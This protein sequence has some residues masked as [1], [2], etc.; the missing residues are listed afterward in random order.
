MAFVV[1]AP[2]SA[3]KRNSDVYKHPE[4]SRVYQRELIR[5]P[6]LEG[7]VTMKCDF[8]THTVFSDGKVWPTVRVDEAWGEGLDAVAITDHIEYRPN[9]KI[10]IAD[11]NESNEIAS[12]HAE[13]IGMIV[14]RGTEITRRK[15][16]G[17]LNALFIRDV[18]KL[19]VDDPEAAID[20]AVRQG[21]FIQ[22]NHPGWPND[23][24]TMYAVHREL[25]GKKKIHGVEVFGNNF[26]LYPK[27]IDW[28]RE[29]GLAAMGNSDIHSTSA[30]TYGTEKMARPMTLVFA[31]ERTAEGIKEA[32]FAGRTLVYFFGKLAGRED[33][34]EELVR[35][36]VTVRAVPGKK[37]LFEITNC[38]DIAYRFTYGDRL[39]VLLPNKILRITLPADRT[40]KFVNCFTGE[41]RN[42]VLTLKE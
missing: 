35:A 24:S 33:L 5:I 23:T 31:R 39:G 38:S 9:R 37:H 27:V 3:Q 25:I 29:T 42:L 17:H 7:Y 2:A 4:M 30:H 15:P 22:W 26:D 13:S 18:N 6:D 40:V 36:S 8:H 14:I 32:L 21:A 34:M 28:C 41:N 11:L 10:V 16:L 12:R 1:A 20:E 19:Q